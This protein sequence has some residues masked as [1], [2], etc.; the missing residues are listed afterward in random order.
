MYAS[1]LWSS[2]LFR[3][4]VSFEVRVDRFL[5]LKKALSIVGRLNQLLEVI[6]G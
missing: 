6:S 4:P 5:N 1:I 3:R 2:R